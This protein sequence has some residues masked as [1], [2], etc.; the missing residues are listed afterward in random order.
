MIC[1]GPGN[2]GGDGL[3]CA[4][5][6]SLHGYSPVIYYPKRPANKPLFANLVTQC[7]KMEL[8]F[9]EEAPS[10]ESMDKDFGV[11]LDALFGF[12]FKVCIC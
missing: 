6:L 1:C 9:V 12:S 7:L 4:R 10:L 3:V 5:H 2:N 8:D 11:I